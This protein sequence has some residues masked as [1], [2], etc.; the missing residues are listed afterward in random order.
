MG[1]KEGNKKTNTHT[2]RL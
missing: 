1:F 2:C